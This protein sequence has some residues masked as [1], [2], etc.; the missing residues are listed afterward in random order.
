MRDYKDTPLPASATSIVSIVSIGSAYSGWCGPVVVFG[1]IS[2]DWDAWQYHS[3]SLG[4]FLHQ[5]V[6]ASTPYHE[7]CNI[8]NQPVNRIQKFKYDSVIV[9]EKLQ[10]EY[11][12]E[13][14]LNT[15]NNKS[16]LDKEFITLTTAIDTATAI[17]NTIDVPTVAVVAVIDHLTSWAANI[18]LAVAPSNAW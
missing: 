17:S 14:F 13:S 9:N 10:V 6:P 8:Q 16:H 7:F 11:L 18:S 2:I 4:N 3:T 1:L 12:L 5:H 15:G